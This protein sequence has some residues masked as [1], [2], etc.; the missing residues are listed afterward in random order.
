MTRLLL[1]AS[2][3]M[4]SL[5]AAQEVP[6]VYAFPNPLSFL[7]IDA[8][9]VV[10]TLDPGG[11]WTN[12]DGPYGEYEMGGS[13]TFWF[14]DEYS[15][16]I[17][18][19]YTPFGA[20]T[21]EG[22]LSNGSVCLGNITTY[23]DQRGVWKT[24]DCPL[25]AISS[26][27]QAN[28]AGTKKR[29]TVQIG[30]GVLPGTEVALYFGSGMGADTIPQCPDLTLSITGARLLAQG[31]TDLDGNLTL[32]RKIPTALFGQNVALQAVDMVACSATPVRQQTF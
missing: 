3:L 21:W 7:N 12:S 1:A 26:S 9:P 23:D 4:P 22:S 5:A 19:P 31:K 15:A 25:G 14:I 24:A 17:P 2:L 11:T 18:A 32:Q 20:A 16:N 30:N 29:L 13:L 28:G 6:A 8:Q 10:F 27:V